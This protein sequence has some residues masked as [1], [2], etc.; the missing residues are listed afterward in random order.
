MSDQQPAYGG[1]DMDAVRAVAPS[2]GAEAA[3]DR[4]LTATNQRNIRALG[5]SMPAG[6]ELVR[7]MRAAI[8]GPQLV[9]LRVGRGTVL[10]K[11]GCYESLRDAIAA[12]TEPQA[13][14]ARFIHRSIN[15]KAGI[16][17]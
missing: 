1:P 9:Y 15:Q 13:S 7:L 17:R 3:R 8:R 10:F 4:A 2:L 5:L 11:L 16:D 14:M 12:G 6:K